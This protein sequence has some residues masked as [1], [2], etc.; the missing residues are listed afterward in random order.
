MSAQKNIPSVPRPEPKGSTPLELY[1]QDYDL[2]A[3][4]VYLPGTFPFLSPV[5]GSTTM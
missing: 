3:P 2:P 1:G 5:A 4:G